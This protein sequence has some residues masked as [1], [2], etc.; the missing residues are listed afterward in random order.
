LLVVITIIG[1]YAVMYYL[2]LFLQ[3]IRGLG[4]MDTGLLMMPFALTAGAMMPIVGNLYDRIGPRLLSVVGVLGL[5][6]VIYTFHN[7]NMSTSYATIIMWSMMEGVAM[8]MAMMPS[9]TAALAVL[10]TDMIS[11]GSAMINILRQVSSSFG[12]A[13]L[14]FMLN[15]RIAVHSQQMINNFT[16]WSLALNDFY[17]KTMAFLG[18]GASGDQVRMLGSAYL[19]GIV[20]QSA[21]VKGIDD[22]F[23]IAAFITLAGVVP[24]LFMKRVR[25]SGALAT[26]E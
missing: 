12:I 11:R 15:A 4:A 16:P 13:V 26:G 23:V 3:T 10:P 17:Q 22:V 6:G 18:G 21:F 20:A 14:T 5:F 2:P 9:T 25:G 24:A 1:M 8:A 19:E 7:V